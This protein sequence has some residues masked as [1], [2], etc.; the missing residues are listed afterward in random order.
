MRVWSS[1]HG[2]SADE[3]AEQD[4]LVILES[5]PEE[6]RPRVQQVFDAIGQRTIRVG[7]A[8]EGTRR[9]FGCGSH[10]YC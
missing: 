3:P 1:V 4:E 7:E 10:S 6:A 2:R 9:R 5:G 8:G